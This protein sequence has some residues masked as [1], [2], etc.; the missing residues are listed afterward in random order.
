MMDEFE[1]VSNTEEPTGFGEVN[2]PVQ[3]SSPKNFDDEEYKEDIYADAHYVPA[4]ENTTPPKFYTPPVSKPR[5]AGPRKKRKGGRVAAGIAAGLVCALLGGI[6]G[7]A[8]VNYGYAERFARLE[9]ELKK[10]SENRSVLTTAGTAAVLP[11]SVKLENTG[12]TSVPAASIYD[13]AC[14]QVVGISSEITVQNVFGMNS[15]AAVSGSGFILTSDGY[16]LTNYHVIEDAYQS[17]AEISVMNHDGEEFPAT[18]V[19]FESDNDIAVIKIDAEGL[20]PVVIG[21]SDAMNVGDVVYAV[22]NPLGELEFSMSTGH[23]SA[24]DRN[25]G[26]EVSA[27]KIHMFQM[28]AA[29]NSGNSGGPVYNDQGQ[30]VGVVTAKY[31]KSGVEGLGFAIPINDAAS[32]ANDIITKGYVTGKAYMALSIRNDYTEMYAQYYGWPM[33]AMVGAVDEG[34]AAEKAGIQAG[35]IITRLGED[36]VESYNDLKAA[37]KNHFAGDT[38]EVT[39]YRAGEEMTLSLTFDEAQPEM[40][41]P[42]EKKP[43]QQQPQQGQTQIMPF[44][45]FF[46]FPI[47]GFSFGF[48]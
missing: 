8:L 16:I 27:E 21:D 31:T 10:V 25:I 47:P 5:E 24:K 45:D 43:Q 26:D 2:E 20:D 35:D 32:I 13:I 12:Y 11:E 36:S 22:G 39:L 46:Q 40:Q 42:Q 34:G 28:D 7:A 3:S 44:E 37:V 41:E 33:G 23:V 48:N 6:G 30:V 17:N 29:V 1:H 18:I 14:R 15:S 4:D 38:V 19:G 9:N